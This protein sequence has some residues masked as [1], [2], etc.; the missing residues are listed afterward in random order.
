MKNIN[1][2]EVITE[3]VVLSLELYHENDKFGCYFGRE[4]D[5][6]IDVK[7]NTPEEAVQKMIPY[8]INYFYK[9]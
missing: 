9:D 7:G 4:C 5:S 1:D 3:E 2:K 8:I 6:G